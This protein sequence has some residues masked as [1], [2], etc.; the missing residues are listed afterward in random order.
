MSVPLVREIL[1]KTFLFS[2]LK[3]ILFFVLK[4][5]SVNH[6]C[7]QCL[8]ATGILAIK[9]EIVRLWASW[10]MATDLCEI[11]L[12]QNTLQAWDIKDSFKLSSNCSEPC[13]G[14]QVDA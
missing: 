8:D 11:A 2:V 7:Q 3:I 1:L 12:S 4:R 13:Y 10:E 6:M 14:W 9:N 5:L